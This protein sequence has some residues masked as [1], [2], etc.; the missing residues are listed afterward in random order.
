MMKKL[1]KFV[2]DHDEAIVAS[3]VTFVLTSVVMSYRGTKAIRANTIDKIDVWQSHTDPLD[4]EVMVTN[5]NGLTTGGK[6]AWDD[7]DFKFNIVL[8]PP[9]AS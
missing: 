4:I 7:P 3:C 5:R 9:V 2:Q 8:D 6:V 1:K